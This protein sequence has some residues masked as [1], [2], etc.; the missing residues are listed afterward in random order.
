L[1]RNALILATSIGILSC[2]ARADEFPARK[3]GLWEITTT[4]KGSAPD[5]ARSCIDEATEADFLKKAKSTMATICSR[6]DI[7]VNGNIVT[8]DSVCRPMNSEQTSHAV[9]T[10]NGDAAY[11]T[12]TTLHYDP[13]FMGKVDTSM[14]QDGKWMGP[15]GPDMQ[16]GDIIT[17]GQ[18]LHLG[19]KP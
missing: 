11:T 7:K 18:K 15:C 1:I 14:T 5:V 8:D 2:A 17:H 3:P 16:P 12:I 6:H 19:G 13:P 10:L 9:T 4:L